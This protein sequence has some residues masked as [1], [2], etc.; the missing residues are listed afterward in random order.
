MWYQRYYQTRLD[1]LVERGK[2][3]VVYGPRRVGKTALIQRFLREYSGRVYQGLGEDQ[4]LKEVFRAPRSQRMKQLFSSYDLLFFDEAQKLP[5]VGTGLKII[6]DLM[7]DIQV[8]ASGSSSFSLSSQL[9]EPLT[10]R[11]DSLLLYPLAVME[12]SAQFGG[13]KIL[14]SLEELLVYGTYP[15]SLTASDLSKRKAFLIR[16]RDS[17]LFKDI[18]ELEN[19]RNAD[20]ISDLL[21]LLAFQI[22]CEVSLNEL[23]NNLG[24][25]KQT[26][27]RYL[28]LLEKSFVIRKVRGFSRNL[29]KEITK[30]SRYYFWDN[31]IRNAVINNFNPLHFRDDVGMLW[32]NFLFIEREKKRSYSGTAANAYFWRTYDRKEIDLI[33][34]YD[35]GLHGYEFKWGQ[36]KT[37][38]KKA[39]IEAY[40]EASLDT[41][42]RSNFLD[43]L[44]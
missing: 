24:L 39:W 4:T 25:A 44:S 1:L 42:D 14:E 43:F 11:H 30:S 37:K 35:G 38:V 29:R 23:G 16:L 15:E 20:K 31:G 17:Y 26:V 27:E 32:E 34:E 18:L 36:K 41:V 19:I 5:Q 13:M 40:P 7:P 2:V 8:I 22:G 21:K 3:L 33:E 10:G 6:V 28:E 12:M 9:G